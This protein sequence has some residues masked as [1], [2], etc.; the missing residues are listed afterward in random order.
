M[1]NAI[2]FA[3]RLQQANSATGAEHELTRI[4]RRDDVVGAPGRLGW[5][6][7]Y[8]TSLYVDPR[9]GV[10]GVLIRKRRPGTLRLPPVVLDFWRPPIR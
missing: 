1:S 4:S 6:G 5:D 10:V 8:S 3:P 2:C 7:A 9:E